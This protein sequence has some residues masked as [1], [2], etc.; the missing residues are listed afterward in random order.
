M[1][2]LQKVSTLIRIELVGP[3]EPVQ[4]VAVSGG[5]LLVEVVL[6]LA[7]TTDSPRLR[8]SVA[9]FF[10][11][12]YR[13]EK[14]ENIR[15]IYSEMVRLA[16]FVETVYPVLVPI[17]MVVAMF[18]F[19]LRHDKTLLLPFLVSIVLVMGS[20]YVAGLATL[21]FI[22]LPSMIVTLLVPLWIAALL[23]YAIREVFLRS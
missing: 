11:K 21:F 3:D 8:G 18:H 23:S 19:G 2:L 5:R 7:H 13:R 15:W 1:N 12:P 20:L 14:G 22:S 9:D 4:S 6:V 10:P 17:V 16:A